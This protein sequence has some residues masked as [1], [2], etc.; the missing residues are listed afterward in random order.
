MDRTIDNTPT[1]PVGVIESLTKGFDTVAG[2]LL[3]M[4]LPLMLDVSLWIGPRIEIDSNQM[5]GSYLEYWEPMLSTVDTETRSG[6]DQMIEV[7]R[8]TLAEHPVR[9]LPQ[10][11]MPTIL[12]NKDAASLPF[13]FSPPVWQVNDP[14]TLIGINAAGMG[15]GFLLL[16]VYLAMIANKVRSGEIHIGSALLRL[17]VNSLWMILLVIIIII[18][19]LLVFLPFVLIA[20]VSSA[21][22]IPIIGSISLFIGRLLVLWM[23]IFLVFSIHGV[24]LNKRHILGAIWDS[25]RVVQWNMSATMFFLILLFVLNL[26]TLM[27]WDLAPMDTWLALIGIAGNAFISTGLLTASFVFYKDRFRYWQ[28]MRALLLERY[29]QRK[30]AQAE[31]QQ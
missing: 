28:E 15:I 23:S 30:A 31:N 19:A 3:L 2:A 14:F 11:L 18:L 8:E 24:F 27:V 6:F 16:C 9:Y 10:F 21:I 29:E 26:A 25:V 12:M 13:N 4:L 1:P 7:F 22:N 5:I 17:P 20:G